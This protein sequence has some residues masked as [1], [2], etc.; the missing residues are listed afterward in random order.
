MYR[1]LCQEEDK[2]QST[3]FL[4]TSTWSNIQGVTYQNLCEENKKNGTVVLLVLVS[5]QLKSRM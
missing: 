1:W 5:W 2:V 4:T 3:V